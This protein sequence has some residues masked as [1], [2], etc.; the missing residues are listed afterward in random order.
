MKAIRDVYG[1]VLKEYGHSNSDIVVLDADVSGSTKSGVFGKEFPDRFFNMGVA[2]ANMIGYAA[3]L[4]TCGKIPF[5]NTFAI[6]MINRGADMIRNA[7]CYGHLNVKFAGGYAGAS[8]SF[9][10]ATHHAIEDVSY[11][12][13]LPNMYVLVPCD[14]HSTS[15]LTKLTIETEGAVYLRLSRSVMPD[16][17]N[18]N[19]KFELGGSHTVR[20][21]SDYT[22]VAYG[23][24]VHK[25]LEAA[26]ILQDKHNLSMRV[27]DM[28]SIKP[29]DKKAI[30]S[31]AKETRG[32][33]SI[34]EHL[35][36]GGLGSIVAETLCESI[37][38]RLK[39]IG[40]QDTFTETGAYEALLS[41][42][43]LGTAEIVEQILEF[44]KG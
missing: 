24:M 17:H 35:I 19:T 5:V 16:L 15:A 42:Y 12:R 38:A 28:Y 6:F 25:A 41:K 11:M 3:G 33:I 20:D 9:D 44:H 32:I 13:T 7:V 21:G 18:S 26:Q 22:I 34:E 1:D 10:G 4:S 30:I 29:I 14:A 36:N 23:Y 40:F 31:A 43:K 8:D 39:R 37:P 2:E 27:I